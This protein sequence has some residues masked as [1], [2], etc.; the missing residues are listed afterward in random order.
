MNIDESIDRGELLS[1]VLKIKLIVFNAPRMRTIIGE[2]YI[3]A[4]KNTL[5]T[6]QRELMDGRGRG[7]VERRGLPYKFA[8]VYCTQCGSDFGPGDNGYSH[9]ISHFGVERNV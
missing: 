4:I 1:L 6:A 9:C 8:N 2:S 3:A 5:D 7:V